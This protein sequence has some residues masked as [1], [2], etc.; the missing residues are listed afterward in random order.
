M[1][2]VAESMCKGTEALSSVA[3]SANCRH[4]CVARAREA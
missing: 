4:V 3:C 2:Y 1:G